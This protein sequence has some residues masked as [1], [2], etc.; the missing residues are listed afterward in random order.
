M[1]PGRSWLPRRPQDRPRAGFWV[2]RSAPGHARTGPGHVPA[3]PRNGF[4]RPKPPKTR[5]ST[6]LRRFFVDFG[7]PMRL[8]ASIS[9]VSGALFERTC[10]RRSANT[11]SQKKAE[12]STASILALALF[13]RFVLRAR[14]S[15][16][17]RSTPPRRVHTSAPSFEIFRNISKYFKIFRSMSEYYRLRR[18]DYGPAIKQPRPL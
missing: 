11:A 17:L 1:L 2:S 14:L 4:E 8:S 12:R 6:I 18:L 16:T 7:S 15:K 5:F 13:A 10:D 9:G 3:R